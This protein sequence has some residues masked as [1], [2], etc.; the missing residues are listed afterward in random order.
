MELTESTTTEK[1]PRTA[2]TRAAAT[3]LYSRSKE[4]RRVMFLELMA[5][6]INQAEQHGDDRPFFE[7][8]VANRQRRWGDRPWAG[9]ANDTA[10]FDQHVASM[11]QV[12]SGSTPK[13]GV[14][15]RNRE[16][17][18]PIAA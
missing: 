15:Y 6:A 16:K 18:P 13:T 3:K 12:F 17:Q 5:W 14:R 8:L 2:I 9:A 4:N 10:A 7:Q 11:A 1:K